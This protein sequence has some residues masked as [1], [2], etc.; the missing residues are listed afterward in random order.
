LL[1]SDE[2]QDVREGQTMMRQVRARCG[3]EEN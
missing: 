1:E 3:E 2:Q